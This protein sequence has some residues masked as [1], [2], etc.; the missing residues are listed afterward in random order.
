MCIRDSIYRTVGVAGTGIGHG[1]L[2][3]VSPGEGAL[4]DTQG[5]QPLLT[6][7]DQ[8]KLRLNGTLLCNRG[9]IG[10]PDFVQHRLLCRCLRVQSVQECLKV[11]PV[12]PVEPPSGSVSWTGHNDVDIRMGQMCIRDRC[13]WM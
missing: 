1:A 10:S 2:Q 7:D 3:F 6:G 9:L 12:L 4:L 8:G 5:Q 11:R 13:R